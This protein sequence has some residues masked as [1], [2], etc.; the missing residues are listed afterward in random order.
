MS[1]RHSKVPS[2]SRYVNTG[3][4]S[5]RIDFSITII[6]SYIVLVHL[7]LFARNL[8]TTIPCIDGSNQARVYCK[9]SI[10]IWPQGRHSYQNL[11][12]TLNYGFELIDFKVHNFSRDQF[13]HTQYVVGWAVGGER[14]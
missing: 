8:R 7:P 4:G 1:T 14:K 6:Y 5:S 10:P 3:P 13:H 11:T 12:F 2:I 9:N